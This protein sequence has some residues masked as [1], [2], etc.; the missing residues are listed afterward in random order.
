MI[1]FLLVNDFYVPFSI[2]EKKKKTCKYV[3]VTLANISKKFVQLDL[4]D[5]L[6]LG[7]SL[8]KTANNSSC[9]QLKSKNTS[10]P[11]KVTFK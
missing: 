6:V 8:C 7:L 9:N 5:C 4:D 1:N 10:R 2:S 11:R 3:I